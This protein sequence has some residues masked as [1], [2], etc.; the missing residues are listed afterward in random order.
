MFWKDFY[1]STNE[2]FNISADRQYYVFTDSHEI[3]GED[4]KT[5]FKKHEGFPLDSLIRFRMFLSI[6]SELEQYDF[7]FFFNANMVFTNRVDDEIFPPKGNDL[8]G[9]LHPG[10]YRASS[11]WFPYERRSASKAYISRNRHKMRY[12]MGSLIGGSSTAFID[13]CI[14]CADWITSDLSNGIIA[15]F[16]DESHL[17]KY[18]ATRAVHALNPGYAFP[19]GSR[20]PFERKI[21]L[22]DKVKHGGLFFSKQTGKPFIIRA[23][24]YIKRMW[25]GILWYFRF[26]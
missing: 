2:F 13:L 22:L 1:S 6:Q 25:T 9:V 24:H 20:I 7:V 19:E 17:N 21:I 11:I 14:T 26:I 16:H 5:I 10:Y 18:F 12:F 8:V 3:G 4:V 23:L 15:V